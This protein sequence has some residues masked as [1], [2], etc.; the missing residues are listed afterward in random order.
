MT[1]SALTAGVPA[2]DRYLQQ[3]PALGRP[4]L[5]LSMDGAD[6]RTPDRYID[7]TAGSFNDM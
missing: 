1:L 2:I 5:L 6:G 3:A 4:P 7:A